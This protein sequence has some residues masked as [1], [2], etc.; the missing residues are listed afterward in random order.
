MWWIIYIIYIDKN[1]K[2]FRTSSVQNICIFL[3]LLKENEHFCNF[4]TRFLV[5]FYISLRSLYTAISKLTLNLKICCAKFLLAIKN[6]HSRIYHFINISSLNP[7][8]ALGFH[9]IFSMCFEKKGIRIILCN[10]F[11]QSDIF[12]PIFFFFFFKPR[13]LFSSI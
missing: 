12:L 6:T 5:I 10:T 11:L 2:G 7:E 13:F 1:N 4:Q 3:H 8:S 9:C